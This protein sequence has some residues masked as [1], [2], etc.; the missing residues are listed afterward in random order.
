LPSRVA[1]PPSSIYPADLYPLAIP[2]ILTMPIDIMRTGI[3][4]DVP[5]ADGRLDQY[6]FQWKVM[7]LDGANSTRMHQVERCIT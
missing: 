2:A 1:L 3:T 6:P 7:H 4:R 5:P